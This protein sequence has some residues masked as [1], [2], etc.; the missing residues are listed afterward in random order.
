[1]RKIIIFLQLFLILSQ[2]SFAGTLD[3]KNWYLYNGYSALHNFS[4]KF[5]TDWEAKISSDERQ[6]FHPKNKGENP[7]YVIEEFTGKNYQEVIDY[8]EDSNFSFFKESDKLLKSSSEDLI[9]KEVIYINKSNNEEISKLFIKRGNLILVLSKNSDDYPDTLETIESTLK[10][11][12]S[13]HQYIDFGEGYSFIFP[14]NLDLNNVD[15]GVEVLTK[16]EKIFEVLKY[17]NISLDKVAKFATLKNE[18]YISQD[19]INFHRIKAIQATYKNTD[20]SKKLDKI[21]V[22]K[23]GDSYGLGSINIENNFPHA[24]YYDDD[25]AEML[26]SFEFFKIEVEEGYASF[27]YFPDVRD[28]HANSSAINSLVKDKVINGYTDGTFKPDGEISR[29]EL[30]KM[31]VA[32]KTIPDG[33]KYNNC[34]TDVK[35]EWFAP[36]ICYAKENGWVSGYKEGKFK[37]EAKINRAEAIK[38][39]LETYYNG[40]V[41]S[42][43]LK[44]G[45]VQDVSTSD[46]FIKYFIYADNRKLLDKQ[47][48]VQKDAKYSYFPGDNITRKEIAEM[49]YR[50]KRL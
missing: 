12:D 5:P 15:S 22:E 24:N 50:L 44:D 28:N 38:I 26:E 48:I 9:A 49:I 33:N 3:S 31:I 23:S 27:K 39:V 14:A 34:F 16:N 10:F 6:S 11:N 18:E 43:G 37:P 36:Y 46:W 25:I 19:N 32:T 35:N 7:P 2:F 1:M 41:A 8:Y 40:K 29:A 47:H 30:T 17:E 45:T 4:V 13:W 20:E 21:F 42:E